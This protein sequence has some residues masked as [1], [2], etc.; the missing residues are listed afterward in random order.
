MGKDPDAGKDGREEEKEQQ[1]MRWLD[2]IS[3]SAGMS[4]S[5]L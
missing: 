5:R 2:S 4:L 1:R 3:D